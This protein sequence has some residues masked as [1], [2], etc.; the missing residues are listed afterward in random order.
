MQA[1]AVLLRYTPHCRVSL[2]GASSTCPEMPNEGA[3][4]QLNFHTKHYQSPNILRLNELLSDT[5]A[6]KK[7][8]SK[9]KKTQRSNLQGL[10]SFKKLFLL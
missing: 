6:V 5:T 4:G 2:K 3:S 10:F 1:G 7:F 9:V 8:K